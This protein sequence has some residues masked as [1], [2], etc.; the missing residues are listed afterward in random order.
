MKTRVWMI[1]GGAALALALVLLVAPTT[2]AQG[3]GG[4][5]GMGGPQ[6]S[7]VAVAAQQL[8][9][10]QAELQAELSAGKSIAQVAGE[11][12]VAVETIVDAFVATRKAR[13]DTA[14]AAGRMTQAQADAMLATVRA[15][16]TAR[17][18]Q[19]GLVGS[20]TGPNYTDADGDGVCDHMGQ[21]GGRGPGAGRGQGGG[22][23]RP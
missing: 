22:R 23:G 15:N 11:K 7:L 20:G 10:T 14:V 3:I 8:G 16:A 2:Q 1:I 21:G 5:M 19:A 9:M 12:D 6:S 17:I 4:G 18:S 13:M